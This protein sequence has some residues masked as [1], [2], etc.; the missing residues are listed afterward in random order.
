M[1]LLSGCNFRCP[2][3]QNPDPTLNKEIS[4]EVPMDKVREYLE[5][6]RDFLDGVV[7]TRVD[8]ILDIDLTELIKEFEGMDLMVKL[9]THR[10]YPLIIED[11]IEAELIDCVSMNVKA[12]SIP[13]IIRRGVPR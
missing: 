11:L 4:S 10:S 2:F 9:D 1:T 8:P 3:C 5:E 13:D 7:I 6:N 12:P